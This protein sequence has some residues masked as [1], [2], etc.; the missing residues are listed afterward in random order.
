MQKVGFSHSGMSFHGIFLKFLY[1]LR[2]SYSTN[3]KSNWSGKDSTNLTK[4]VIMPKTLNPG[5][6]DIPQL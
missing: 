4:L 6:P 2:S 3:A 5:K 1:Q